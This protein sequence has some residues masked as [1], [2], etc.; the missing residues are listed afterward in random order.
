MEL[1]L[2]L[3]KAEQI[4]NE[5]RLRPTCMYVDK[6][7]NWAA[8]MQRLVAQ[9]KAGEVLKQEAL[10]VAADGSRRLNITG[11]RAQNPRTVSETPE[12]YKFVGA[13]YGFLLKLMNQVD[14][15]D[16][17]AFVSALIARTLTHGDYVYDR[18][19]HHYP[20]LD[21]KVSELPLVAE[22]AIRTGH[23]KELF[24][25][26]SQ[27]KNPTPG[28]A[29]LMMQLADTL[30]FNFTIFPET[31]L[32]M[33]GSWL[34]PLLEM[35]DLQTHS[36]RGVRA[37]GAMVQNPHYKPGREREAGMIVI[38]IHHLLA[39][40]SQALFFYLKG[41][42][43]DIPSLEIDDDRRKVIGV[44]ESLGFDPVL[45]A[46][47]QKAEDLYRNTAD[48][49][50]LKS[51]I[52]HLRSF[53]E[54]V[55]IQAAATFAAQKQESV[56]DEFDPSVTLLKNDGTL[57]WQQERFA[58]GLYTLLSS[59]GVHSLTSEREFARMLRNMVIEYHLM[60]LSILDKQ[61][62]KV[63]EASS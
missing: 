28:L 25:L 61:S 55:H 21:G 2:A 9:L 60:F 19:Q 13:N 5:E 29:L 40:I 3:Y 10:A 7:V 38:Q 47:L 1:K 62:F 50:D 39:E 17:P 14:K 23:V 18:N 45:T 4:L 32:E 46:S 6:G 31:D 11:M 8:E 58:R 24:E 52:G 51:C 56:K 36:A 49:F 35:A 30:S 33:M 37:S 42:L 26:M 48:A 12:Q 27:A 59:E 53:Y 54:H 44:I 43:Q 20:E 63:R 34:K 16:L 41:A 22:F 57:T 15:S